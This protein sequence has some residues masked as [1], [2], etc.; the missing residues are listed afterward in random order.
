MGQTIVLT[1]MV[2]SAVP[3]GEYDRRITI[4]TKERGKISAFARGARRPGNPLMAA[5][6]PFSFGKFEA[7]EGRSSYTVVKAEIENYFRELTEDLEGTCYGFYFLEIAD[8]YARENA[9]EV[10]MLKLLYQSLR[11]LEKKSLDNRL[12]RRIFELKTMVI[13][14]EYPNVFS[15]LKCGREEEL[16]WFHTGSGGTLCEE[17]RKQ[18]V[19]L[20]LHPSTLYAMQYIITSSIE[21]LYTFAVSED[22]L[23]NLAEIMNEYMAFYM[24]RKFHSLQILEENEGFAAQNFLSVSEA[25]NQQLQ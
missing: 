1:G 23:K 6:S 15:C 7:Y 16:Y 10:H 20:S 9:D 19:S 24:E 14:G 5:G 4:L 17:C 13:N 11:A 25:E 21:K 3:V 2:L 22:V 12:I 18:T 8:Y